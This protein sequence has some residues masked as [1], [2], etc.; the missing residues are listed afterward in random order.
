M[1]NVPFSTL[2]LGRWQL[3]QSDV[4]T[5]ECKFTGYTEFQADY[6]VI[7]HNGCT[8]F[9]VPVGTWTVVNDT[10]TLT[11]TDGEEEVFAI[12][13]FNEDAMTLKGYVLSFNFITGVITIK[14]AYYRYKKH[15][16]SSLN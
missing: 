2:I 3:I 9:P 5:E 13:S 7:D 4:D 15:G 10:L 16:Q 14:P 1:E 11:K 6:T 12:T 8:D